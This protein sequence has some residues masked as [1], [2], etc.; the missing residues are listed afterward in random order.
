MAETTWNIPKEAK[1][2]SYEVILTKASDQKKGAVPGDAAEGQERQPSWTSGRFRVEEFR[3]PLTKG[4]IQ[5][6]ADPLVKPQEIP[7]DLSVQYLAGGGAAFLPVKFRH[8]I[9]ADLLPPSKDSMS[10][11]LGMVL[12]KKDLVRGETLWNRRKKRGNRKE[13]GLHR[14]RPILLWIAM[15]RFDDPLESTRG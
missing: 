2:G 4:T 1:L 12:S 8:E 5:P 15:E 9:K 7:F 14:Q 6:P 11:S 3:I 13:G 10:S